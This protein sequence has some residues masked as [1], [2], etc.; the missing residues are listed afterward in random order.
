MRDPLAPGWPARGMRTDVEEVASEWSG[1]YLKWTRAR[2][3]SLHAADPTLRDAAAEFLEHRSGAV[4]RATWSADRTA[5]GHLTREFP[6]ATK[7]LDIDPRDL[8]R[9]VDHMVKDGYRASTLGTYIKSWRVFFGRLGVDP[10]AELRVSVKASAPL[11]TIETLG[12]AECV[13]IFD[14]ARKVDALQL[15]EFPS[16]VLACGLGLYAGLRQGEIFAAQWPEISQ[17]ERIVR[18]SYQVPKDSTALRPTKGKY[19]RAALVLPGWWEHHRTD[20]IGFVVGRKGRPVGSRTQRNLITRV[21]DTAGL[22]RLGLGYHIFRHTYAVNF[23]EAGGTMEE[24]QQSL[25]H[26]SIQTTQ[27]RYDHRKSDRTAKRA[28]AR[29]YG[30]E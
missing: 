11:G 4:E 8:Q 1:A 12:A 19:V 24:L 2:R 21:L 17:A 25:G 13:R 5:L 18:V 29:I 14:A 22:N 30:T 28:G 16:A 23:L 9:I 10:A 6:K 20:A 3:H 26:A 7:V 15:G 27:R